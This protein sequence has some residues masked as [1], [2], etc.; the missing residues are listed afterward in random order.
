MSQKNLNQVGYNY[1]D[2]C[3]KMVKRKVRKGGDAWIC[4]K[5]WDKEV[6]M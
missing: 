6:K 5:H 3:E 4:A 2:F 1:C